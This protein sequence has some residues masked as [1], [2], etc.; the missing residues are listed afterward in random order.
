[1]NAIAELQR[2]A[3]TLSLLYPLTA[4]LLALSGSLHWLGIDLLAPL[5][6]A[7]NMIAI[8]AWSTL[9]RKAACT[10]GD[11]SFLSAG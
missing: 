4:S 6:L 9:S 5:L 3:L 1:M 2:R 11:I 7:L 10:D 8:A